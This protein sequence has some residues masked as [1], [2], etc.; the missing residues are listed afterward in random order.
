MVCA[1]KIEIT[2]QNLRFCLEIVAK[3][4]SCQGLIG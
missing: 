2:L 3:G 4:T 1:L